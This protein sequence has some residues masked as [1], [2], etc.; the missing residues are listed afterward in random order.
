MPDPLLCWCCA[1]YGLTA[2]AIDA[3]QRLCPYCLNTTPAACAAQHK[4]QAL[5]AAGT[6]GPAT[7]YDPS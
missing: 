5:A 7:M 2:P 3:R 1:L 6:P 4:Q